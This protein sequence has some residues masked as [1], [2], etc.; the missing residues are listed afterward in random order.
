MRDSWKGC[1]AEKTDKG[2]KEADQR[3][4][5]NHVISGAA[6]AWPSCHR[7]LGREHRGGEAVLRIVLG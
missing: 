4:G 2:E 1:S 3:G 5:K 6:D 7:S